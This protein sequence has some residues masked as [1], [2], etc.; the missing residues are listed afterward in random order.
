MVYSIF[1]ALKTDLHFSDAQL[2]LIGS[3]FAWV[4]SLSMPFSGRLADR[5]RRDRLIAGSMILWSVATFACG[6]ST[7]VL[8]FLFWRAVMGITEALYYPAAVGML[9]EAHPGATRSRALGIHQSAQFGCIIIGGTYGGWMAD[10][11]SW[12]T[13]FAVAAAAGVL[14]S[15]F[16]VW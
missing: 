11:S 1:P 14:Y 3:V 13:G 5:V 2:G 15:V 12:R 8:L 9:A 10:H 7:S 16:L 6:L 4:Y